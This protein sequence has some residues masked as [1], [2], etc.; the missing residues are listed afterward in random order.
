MAHKT[1]SVADVLARNT[2][3][4]IHASISALTGDPA[5]SIHMKFTGYHWK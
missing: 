2:E 1:W 3:Q 4:G 5:E